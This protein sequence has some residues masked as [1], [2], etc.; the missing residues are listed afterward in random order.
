[1]FAWASTLNRDPV[2]L[3]DR[4]AIE[5]A[6]TLF[7]AVGPNAEEMIQARDKRPMSVTRGKLVV[8]LFR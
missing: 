6:V 4:A 1:L 3:S 8:G 7:A 5:R 2:P